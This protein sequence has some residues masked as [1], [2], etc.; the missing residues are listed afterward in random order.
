MKTKRQRWLENTPP[1]TDPA[2]E[3]KKKGTVIAIEKQ[4]TAT[5]TDT[6][7]GIPCLAIN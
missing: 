7:P 4:T 2:E 5:A 1:A 3:R 6:A